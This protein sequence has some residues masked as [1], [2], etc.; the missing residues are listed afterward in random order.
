MKLVRMLKVFAVAAGLAQAPFAAAQNQGSG[1]DSPVYFAPL[2]KNDIIV[3]PTEYP[4]DLPTG[5]VAKIDDLSLTQ[6]DLLKQLLRTNLAAITDNLINTKMCELELNREAVTVEDAE[7]QAELEELMPRISPGKTVEQV[8]ES[9]LFS[10]AYLE[11]TAR[12][13][14]GWKKLFWK[15]RSI[16]EDQRTNQANQLLLQLYM[17]EVK[18]RYQ[19]LQRGSNPPPPRGAIAALNTII[20]GKKVAYTVSPVEAMEFMIGILRPASILQGQSLLIDNAVVEREMK[21]A[22]VL[23]TDTEIEAWVR[24]MNEKYPDPFNWNTILRLKQTTADEERERF[25][26]IQAWKRATKTEITQAEIDAFRKEHEDYFRSRHVKVSHILVKCVD[27]VTGQS[28]G[29]E[30]EAAALATAQKVAQLVKEGVDFKKLA[31]RFSEDDATAKNGGALPQ[32]IKKWGGGYDPNFQKSAYAM[33]AGQ[34]TEP[35]RSSIGYHI[36]Q[37]NEV[38]PATEREIDWKDERYAEWIVD[39]YETIKMREWRDGLKAKAKIEKVDLDK[40]LDIKRISFP[41]KVD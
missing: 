31:E 21:K 26:H 2:V 13:S 30:A 9:G 20:K 18:G 5:Q 28:K 3:V 35:V 8:V 14:R 39:E 34:V 36:I 33:S 32:P 10:R 7:I 29:P 19:I 27:E 22:D 23:V 41:K 4:S 11:R 25:R 37:C 40:L 16:P 24:S 1:D 17:N 15:A 38:T 12:T 6:A